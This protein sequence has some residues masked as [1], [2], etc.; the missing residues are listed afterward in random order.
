MHAALACEQCSIES[1][2]FAEFRLFPFVCVAHRSH[3]TLASP[4]CL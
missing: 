4:A 3:I 1:I 2:L